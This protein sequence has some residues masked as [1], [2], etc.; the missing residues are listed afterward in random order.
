MIA[1]KATD[2]KGQ[3]VILIGLSYEDLI[4]IRRAG[5]T[6]ELDGGQQF[7]GQKIVVFAG[8]SDDANREKLKRKA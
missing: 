2:Q 8:P 5:N 1:A 7:E 4:A 3:E 6:R